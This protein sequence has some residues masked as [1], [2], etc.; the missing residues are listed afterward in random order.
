M[1]SLYTTVLLS[2]AVL[3]FAAQEA[4]AATCDGTIAASGSVT[5]HT[6]VDGT[7]SVDPG[8]V[9]NGIDLVVVN[10]DPTRAI[11][12]SLTYTSN[13]YDRLDPLSI[14]GQLRGDQRDDIHV[15]LVYGLLQR[16]Q[17]RG[18]K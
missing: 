8:F 2:V 3:G 1:K 9:A 18:G 11:N 7:P 13:V 15:V 10:I 12:V 17:R 16:G 5:Y 6:W 14:D 4:L